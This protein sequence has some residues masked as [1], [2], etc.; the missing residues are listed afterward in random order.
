MVRVLSSVFVVASLAA[1][2]FATAIPTVEKRGI[3]GLLSIIQDHFRPNM[4]NLKESVASAH[5]AADI[6]H[7]AVTAGAICTDMK[8][9]AAEANAIKSST[10]PV[11]DGDT[12]KII[13][14]I[15]VCK[16]DMDA[17]LKT[18]VARRNDPDLAV[19]K[20]LVGQVLTQVH[21]CF[22]TAAS[23]LLG[24][25]SPSRQAEAGALNTEIDVEFKAAIAAYA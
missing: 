3:D 13:Q 14:A 8:Q 15:N 1:S 12:E 9:T 16:P 6:T 24:I 2:S 7:I 10:G 11:S 22:E 17:T 25:T 20:S 5:N 21:V 23:A 18:I 19:S 4:H